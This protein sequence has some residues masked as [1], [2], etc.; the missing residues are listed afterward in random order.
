[1]ESIEM[2][3]EENTAWN[4]L[5]SGVVTQSNWKKETIQIV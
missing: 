5:R 3:K 2:L 1:M 4:V